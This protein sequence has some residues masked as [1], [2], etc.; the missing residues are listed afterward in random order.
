ML[1]CAAAMQHTCNR[2]FAAKGHVTYHY[3]IEFKQYRKWKEHDE[4]SKL[5]KKESPGV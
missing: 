4:I 3:G 1:M 5:V 2:P